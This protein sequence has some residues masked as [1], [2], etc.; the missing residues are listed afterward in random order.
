MLV[1]D[2]DGYR[3]NVGI[4]VANQSGQVLWARRIGQ[5]AWQFPQGG[6]KE[7]ESAEQALYREL[8]EELGL[9]ERS[10]QIIGETKAWLRYDLPQRFVRKNR[11]PVCIGQKQRWFLLGLTDV[12]A[13]VRLDLD[14]KPEFD[15]WKWVNYWRPPREVIF[16]KR[17]VY[18]RALR[19][20][21]PSLTRWCRLRRK[22]GRTIG[23]VSNSPPRPA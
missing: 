6:I 20:L 12:E 22:S 10:V 23:A 21:Q 11:Q 3:P 5:D 18:R 16:F 4:I 13:A 17:Q 1:I 19:E 2:A 15:T 14:E 8:H 7:H 9:T